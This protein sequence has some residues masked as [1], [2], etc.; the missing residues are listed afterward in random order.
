MG[1]DYN[2]YIGPYALCQNEKVNKE[3]EM[4]TCPKKS[5]SGHK[6][7]PPHGAKFCTQCGAEFNKVPIVYKADRIESWEL[8]EELQS[9]VCVLTEGFKGLPKHCDV[10][11]GNG[12]VGKH[13]D[14]KYDTWG[15]ELES[16]GEES[17]QEFEEECAGALA[18]LREEYGEE[19]VEI[20]WGTFG[21]MS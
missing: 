7:H 10:W 3:D 17:I 21:W 14:P 4:H 18:R 2:V 6:K 1:V 9:Q 12:G 20:K 11:I 13:F 16:V 19:N 15:M 8:M 5:C